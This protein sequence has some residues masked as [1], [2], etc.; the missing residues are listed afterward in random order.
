MARD[1]DR[2]TTH[3]KNKKARLHNVR[4]TNINSWFRFGF[5][6]NVVCVV[7]HGI[8]F[9]ERFNEPQTRKQNRFVVG[10]GLFLVV[11]RVRVVVGC[12]C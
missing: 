7:F 10:D 8:R 4:T 9:R 5:Y 3:N 6:R 11:V 1:V 12:N 2:I